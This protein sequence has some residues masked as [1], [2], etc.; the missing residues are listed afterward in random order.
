VI[1]LSESLRSKF[2][3]GTYLDRS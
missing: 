2:S 3:L 1:S